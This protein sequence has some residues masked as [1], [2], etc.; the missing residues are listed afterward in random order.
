MTFAEKL[1]QLRKAKGFTKDRLAQRV[2]ISPST[3]QAWER[4]GTAP[5]VG[6]LKLLSTALG[7]NVTEFLACE[8]PVDHR[9]REAAVES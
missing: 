4:G 5:G 2:G 7:I 6:I 1:R 3:L 8:F 9:R